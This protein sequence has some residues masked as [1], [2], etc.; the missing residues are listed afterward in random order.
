MLAL[1]QADTHPDGD[2]RDTVCHAGGVVLL[3]VHTW[4]D[5]DA[6]GRIISVR[7]ATRRERR[8]YEDG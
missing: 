6:P 4:P 7:K 3:I 1:S 2:R 8:A 5:D